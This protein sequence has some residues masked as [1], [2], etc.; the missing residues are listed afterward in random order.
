MPILGA[1]VLHILVALF[2]AVH[3]VR[4]GQQLYWLLI[5]FMFPGLG[6]IVYFVAIYLP[7][8]R[9]DHGA[10]KAVAVAARVLDPERELREARDAFDQTIDRISD[11]VLGEQ[12]FLRS[13]ADVLGETF[14]LLVLRGAELAADGQRTDRAMRFAAESVAGRVR[15]SEMRHPS[16]H[17]VAR[18]N[19]PGAHRRQLTAHSAPEELICRQFVK[20]A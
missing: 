20:A 19:S 12:G 17:A 13:V 10:R 11:L 15:E 9:L 3:V 16:L 18:L 2:F 5:L 1:G 6:S 7:D 14:E 8:S 4:T